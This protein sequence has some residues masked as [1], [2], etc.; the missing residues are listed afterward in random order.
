[1]T[2]QLV[3]IGPLSLQCLCPRC[4]AGLP[5]V[6]YRMTQAE[7]RDTIRDHYAKHGVRNVWVV[8]NRG[9]VRVCF[10]DAHSV[11]YPS[12]EVALAQCLR[13]GAGVFVD[14]APAA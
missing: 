7:L 14:D 12:A 9:T 8:W 1:M 6:E 13:F 10:S 2:R 5:H 4:S 3:D 11:T